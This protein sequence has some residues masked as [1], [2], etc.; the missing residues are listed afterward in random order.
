[1]ARAAETTSYRG[2]SSHYLSPHRRDPV[3][4][5]WEEPVNH[6]LLASAIEAL[7]TRGPLRVLDVGAGTGDGL[8]LLE[9]S[10][11]LTST[12]SRPLRYLG[13]DP[14][15][16]MIRTAEATY[17]HRDD[18]GFV[19][20][21]V[22][23]ALPPVEFDLYLSTGVPYSHLSHADFDEAL[24]RILIAIGRGP[25]PAAIVLDVLG[26]YSIEWTTGWDHDHWDYPMSFFH[27]ADGENPITASMSFHDRRSV[28]RALAR[29]RRRAPA[30][31]LSVEFH[32]R[33]VMVGRHTTT[34]ALNPDLPNYRSLVNRLR[35]GDV[36][37]DLDSLRFCAPSRPA[38]AEVTG[39]FAALEPRWN[40]CLE[41]SERSEARG[42]AS[43]RSRTRLADRLRAL[44]RGTQQGLGAAHSLICVVLAAPRR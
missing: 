26:R 1:M 5:L 22:R 21:D 3:K 11:T 32:D 39:F 28:G 36:T 7:P 19:I 34:A 6:R 25:G 43:S 16:E 41:L 31:I 14:D 8:A 15:E 29:A 35:D 9:R 4:Q 18:A 20:G 23:D 2:A 44:E 24:T 17:S 38:P 12:P 42:G 27:G 30:E 37:V 40:A 13:L 33:S 10:L